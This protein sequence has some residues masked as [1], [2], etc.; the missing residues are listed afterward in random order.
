M[1]KF[2]V[3]DRVKFSTLHKNFGMAWGNGIATLTIDKVE[4][5]PPSAVPWVGHKQWVHVKES[6]D[7]HTISGAFFELVSSAP[8][9]DPAKQYR[10]RDGREVR[11]Y[12]VDGGGSRSVH[13]AI[14]NPLVSDPD[15]ISGWSEKKWRSDG[16]HGESGCDSPADLIEVKPEQVV[17][18]V[19]R[20]SERHDYFMTYTSKPSATEC[21]NAV[22][23]VAVTIHE[24]D[25]L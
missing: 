23:M 3:G 1:Q 13:G 10:T 22:A 4:D 24:G 21:P 18:L 25:G 17:W 8:D 20:R 16:K 12:A 15:W 14:Y 6:P 7:S 11:I 5:V 19:W 9:I 2:K